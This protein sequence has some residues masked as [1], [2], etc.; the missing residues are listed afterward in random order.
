MA[1]GTAMLLDMS[2]QRAAEI[3]VGCGAHEGGELLQGVA[4]ARPGT[5]GEILEIL[6]ANVRARFMEYL[7]PE[8]A[9][10]VLAAMDAGDA[11][12][13]VLAPLI[14]ADADLA[15]AAIMN[16]PA[17]TAVGLIREVVPR[18]LA[19]R[20]VERT[21]ESYVQ[22]MEEVDR[23]VIARLRKPPVEPAGR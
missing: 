9:A 18:D 13:H 4:V 8:T 12:V 2:P 6:S 23:G 22:A 7:N 11:A 1:V 14:R 19:S 21:W 5:A 10:S 3:L 17:G 16:L 20:L 15:A